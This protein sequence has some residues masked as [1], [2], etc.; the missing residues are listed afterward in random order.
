MVVAVIREVTDTRM[1]MMM[2]VMMVI[3]GVARNLSLRR[4]SF[5]AEGQE[6]AGVL[7]KDSGPPP[8]QIGGMRER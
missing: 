5:D 2:L 1:M 7:R 6:R 4:H 8:H 3:L